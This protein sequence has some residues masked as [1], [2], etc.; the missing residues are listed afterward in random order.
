MIMLERGYTCGY[1]LFFFKQKRAAPVGAALFY[2]F[3]S[4][5]FRQFPLSTFFGIFNFETKFSQFVADHI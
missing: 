4:E 2:M 1:G 3:V 5:L